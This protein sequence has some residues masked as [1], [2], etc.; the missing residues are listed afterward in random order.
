MSGSLQ[1][2]V[3]V[4]TG[5]GRG[6]GR[7]VACEL[8]GR[9]CAVVAAS[10]TPE[11]IGET[12][13]LIREANGQAI[14]LP[15]DVAEHESAVNLVAQTLA[16]YGRIDILVNNAGVQ[17]PIGP[18]QTNDWRAW[19]QNV[20]I[21]L[22]GTFNLC[23]AV[24]PTMLLQG[25]G[26][27]INMSGGGA[28]APRP[29][30]TAYGA[31]KAAIVRL[32]ETLA[33]E[34]REENIQVNAVAPGAVNTRMLDELLEAGEIAG[35][36]LAAAQQRKERGGTSP[37]IAAKLVAF[38]VSDASGN[39]TGKLI[40]APYD[41]WDS[42]DEE[43]IDALNSSPWLTLRRL[44]PHTLGALGLVGAD[45]RKPGYRPE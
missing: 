31:A 29:N 40:A 36:E 32:T 8:G 5:A 45:G 3:A 10:R 22:F 1:G 42:W 16:E 33:E 4:V 39:L 9:G 12:A 28:T 17:G 2:R 15:V 34:V 7:A 27:I 18:L 14:A 24:L 6:I 35:A 41:G 23:H 30:F 44:D 20:A 11:E 38:L 43:V 21:N 37:S 25:A 13:Q 19:Q 26:K